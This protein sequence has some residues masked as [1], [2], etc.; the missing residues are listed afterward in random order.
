MP[1]IFPTPEI[2]L[3]HFVKYFPPGLAI[4]AGSAGLI[5]LMSQ[6]KQLKEEQKAQEVGNDTLTVP[7]PQKI[8][9]SPWATALAGLTRSM[10]RTA[11]LM[12]TNGAQVAQPVAGAAAAAAPGRLSG[13]LSHLGANKWRY[14]SGGAALGATGMAEHMSTKDTVPSSLSDAGMVTAILA[15]G[16]LGGY[17]MV[18]NALENRQKEQLQTRLDRSKNEYGTLLGQTLAGGK[19]ATLDDPNST[20]PIIKGICMQVVCDEFGEQKVAETVGSM[21]FGAPGALSVLTAVLAHKWMYN[22]QNE[23][24]HMHTQTKPSP[25]KQIRLVSAPPPA[26][27]PMPDDGM[28]AGQ[29]QL[30]APKVAGELP[31]LLGALAVG[32]VAGGEK[33]EPAPAIGAP[34]V[35]VAPPRATTVGPGTVQIS[36]DGGPTEVE[37][38]DPAAAAVLHNGG[39][40]K[41]TTLMSIFQAQPEVA[42]AA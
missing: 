36:T 12:L 21:M 2:A 3:H 9:S 7:I 27:A 33:K 35:V 29:L 19:T 1:T 42:A 38:E 34:P 6:M 13:L 10:R 14:A 11:P 8:A 17:H 20:F 26:P 16:G 15:A 37:A 5:H 25:P 40:K 32:H 31:E 30:E 41:L 4:G 28:S 39:A 24:E 18:D 23:L 22:R